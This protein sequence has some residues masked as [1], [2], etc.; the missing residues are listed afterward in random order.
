MQEQQH[1]AQ[2]KEEYT[3][4]TTTQYNQQQNRNGKSSFV[5]KT[6]N[7]HKVQKQQ[8]VEAINH[9]SIGI[10]SMLPSPEHPNNIYFDAGFTDDIVVGMDGGC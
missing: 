4:K 7:T 9:K 6:L 10:H 2:T 5:I 8:A 3:R 1:T